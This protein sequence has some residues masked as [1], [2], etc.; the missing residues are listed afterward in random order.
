[1]KVTSLSGASQDTWSLAHLFFWDIIPSMWPLQRS[2]GKGQGRATERKTDAERGDL[3]EGD[4]VIFT[5]SQPWGWLVAPRAVRG[6]PLL[7]S[8]PG[9]PP[10]AHHQPCLGQ[11]L[12]PRLSAFPLA[13]HP[14]LHWFS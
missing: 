7:L 2:L 3:G 6:S 8:T 9:T 1:M 4:G 13:L 10:P 11:D 5:E 14:S 12:P